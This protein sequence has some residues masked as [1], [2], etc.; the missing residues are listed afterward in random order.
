MKIAATVGLAVYLIITF[1]LLILFS[2]VFLPLV[3]VFAIFAI[4]ELAFLHRIPTLV[5]ILDVWAKPVE[6]LII[7]AGLEK[8]VEARL[9][10]FGEKIKQFAEK[11]N[12][13]P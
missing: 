11:A 4:F 5:K 7:A 1:V 13:E 3:V 12:Q 10:V 2:W 9:K 6:K 8:A